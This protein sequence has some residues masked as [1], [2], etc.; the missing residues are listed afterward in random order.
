[1]RLKEPPTTPARRKE[2]KGEKQKNDVPKEEGFCC[3]DLPKKR[4]ERE[5]FTSSQGKKGADL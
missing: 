1:M 5:K 3:L 4:Q 2:E